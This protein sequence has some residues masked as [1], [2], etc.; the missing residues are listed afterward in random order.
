M[1]E[2]SITMRFYDNSFSLYE[3]HF[4][5]L[6][7]LFAAFLFLYTTQDL[8]VDYVFLIETAIIY[9]IVIRKQN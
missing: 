9:E 4:S 5:E 2:T 1:L 3:A 6:V 7:L 8:I